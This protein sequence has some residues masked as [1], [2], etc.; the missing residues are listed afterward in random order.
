VATDIHTLLSAGMSDVIL[1]ATQ[2]PRG[3]RCMA[4]FAGGAV[5]FA[6]GMSPF[7]ADP[8]RRPL[9]LCR[10]PTE[11]IDDCKCDLCR[12]NRAL[13]RRAAAAATAKAK[14]KAEKGRR[15]AAEDKAKREKH[16][17]KPVGYDTR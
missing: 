15:A 8:A 5:P 3:C 6:A 16:G 17:Q 12:S 1:D 14:A 9:V 7:A 13:Q 10:F 11:C 2:H 4:C